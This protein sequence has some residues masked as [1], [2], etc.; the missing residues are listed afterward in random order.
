MEDTNLTGGPV[1]VTKNNR[2]CL[3]LAAGICALLCAACAFLLPVI[4]QRIRTLEADMAAVDAFLQRPLGTPFTNQAALDAFSRP[5]PTGSEEGALYVYASPEGVEFVGQ[6]AAWDETALERLC[7]ELLLNRHGRGTLFPVQGHCLPAGG[8]RR[9]RHPRADVRERDAFRLRFP[10]LPP[11]FEIGFQRDAGLVSLYAEGAGTRRPNPWRT[12][13][14]HEYGHHYT[15]YHM[16]PG[17]TREQQYLDSEYFRLRGLDPE[18]VE[19]FSQNDDFYNENHHRFLF[20]IAAEDYVVLM[21]SPNSRAVGN[22]CDVPDEPLRYHRRGGS[23]AQL[24]RT[25]EFSYAPHAL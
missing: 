23:A 20:E 9:A 16:F 2:R 11:D 18:T 15:F 6:S 21:G 25:G 17:F 19:V 12:A 1:S 10:A 13:S 14:S 7:E 24:Y 3:Y 22:Y 5:T 4:A 8:R